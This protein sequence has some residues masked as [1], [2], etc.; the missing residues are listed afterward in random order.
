MKGKLLLDAIEWWRASFGIAPDDT[1]AL[2]VSRIDDEDALRI[3]LLTLGEARLARLRADVYEGFLGYLGGKESTEAA[4]LAYAD[5]IGF[6]W[7]APDLMF[8][9]DADCFSP[10]VSDDPSILV[11]RLGPEDAAA[12]EEM[13]AAC[14]EDDL[15]N[16]YVELDHDLVFGAFASGAMVS[17]TSAYGMYDRDGI[18][19]IGYVS[20][21]EA[22]GKGYGKLCASMITQ[23]IFDSGRIAMIRAQPTNLG[24]VGIARALGFAELGAWRYDSI[25]GE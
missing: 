7:N 3:S 14:S 20:R 19:D 6:E 11:K 10:Y 25:D 23:A 9:A 12:F 15:D 21:P 22:R 2:P 1:G 5:S 16:G 8:F 13:S 24:S 4:L 18:F 17:R